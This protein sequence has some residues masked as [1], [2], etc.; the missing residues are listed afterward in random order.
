MT[1]PLLELRA[2]SKRFGGLSAIDDLSFTIPPESVFSL[3]GPNGA[4]KSTV[5]NVITGLYTPNSGSVHFAGTP[6]AGRQPRQIVAAG[7]ARTFQNIRLFNNATA[8]ENVAV[9]RNVRYPLRLL[10]TVFRTPAYRRQEAEILEYTRECLRFT[11]LE[12][13]WNTLACNLSYGQQRRLEIARALA[14]E[15]RLLLLD[16]P[17]AGMNPQETE[18]L[19]TLIRAIRARGISVLLIEH[20]M[21]LVMEISDQIC[22]V[23]FGKKIAE[24]LPA[25]IRNHPAV[26]EAYLGAD[27]ASA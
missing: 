24:G 8:W 14:T 17:A 6:L 21:P 19:V 4:G 13:A 22:V 7:I 27:D 23:N 26:I 5:F 16:E 10:S 11:G 18:S 2:V 20:D 3:I 1:A 15:P 12:S 9:A 25:E